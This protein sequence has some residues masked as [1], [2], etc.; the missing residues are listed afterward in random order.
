MSARPLLPASRVS[1]VR[2]AGSI[3]G[4]PRG[5]EL[6]AKPTAPQRIAGRSRYIL[7]AVRE[8]KAAICLDSPGCDRPGGA[9]DDVALVTGVS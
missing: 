4:S 9:D 8:R 2:S 7:H 6:A 5:V 1:G 3:W